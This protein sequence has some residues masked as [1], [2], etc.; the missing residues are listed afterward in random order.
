AILGQPDFL[1]TSTFWNFYLVSG[2]YDDNVKERITQKDRAFGLFLD[3][4]NHRVWVKSWADLILDAENRLDFIQTKLQIEVTA[5]EISERIA[6]LKNS[7]LRVSSDTQTPAPVAK[8]QT[9]SEHD[10][11]TQPS[12]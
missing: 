1:G 3:K 4:P 12:A 6:Q 10:L 7:V 2:E 9:Q 5:E 8:R 11:R